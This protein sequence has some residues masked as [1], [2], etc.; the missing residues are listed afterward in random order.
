MF[1][2]VL[3]ASVII[4]G[5]VFVLMSISILLKKNGKFPN[6]HIGGNKEMAKRGI[7]CATTMDKMERKKTINIK[8]MNID[9]NHESTTTSC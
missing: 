9:G 2:T 1:W 8:L 3:L 6:S 7:F 5:I 4:V